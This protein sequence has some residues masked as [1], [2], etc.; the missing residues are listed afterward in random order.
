MALGLLSV[1]SC[2]HF[3]RSPG[4]EGR[5]QGSC[6]EPVLLTAQRRW[7]IRFPSI[8]PDFSSWNGVP[9]GALVKDA[10]WSLGPAKC[11]YP[12]TSC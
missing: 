5:S 7:A 2:H 6:L 3:P 1:P 8:L 12:E 9:A 11:P 4:A 10:H